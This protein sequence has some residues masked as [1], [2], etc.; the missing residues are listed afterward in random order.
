MVLLLPALV[1]GVPVQIPAM[2]AAAAL[3]C[4]FLWRRRPALHWSMLPW[5]PLMLT[6]GLF[7]VESIWDRW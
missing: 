4:L 2:A 3:L 6:S 1:S 7:M 5:R